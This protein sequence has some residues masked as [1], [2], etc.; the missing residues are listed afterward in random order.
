M[1]ARV[2]S[3]KDGLEGEPAVAISVLVPSEVVVGVLRDF[4]ER[5]PSVLLRHECRDANPIDE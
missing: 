5:F 4:G 1:R 2:K 3:L